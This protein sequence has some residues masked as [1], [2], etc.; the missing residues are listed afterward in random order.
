M[1][2]AG[3]LTWK[4]HPIPGEVIAYGRR[5][6]TWMGQSRILYTAEGRNSSVAISLGTD[7]ATEVDVNGHVE[8][9]TDPTT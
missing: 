9:T 2:V 8:A 6:S 1:I 7:G 3:F 5:V 4:M